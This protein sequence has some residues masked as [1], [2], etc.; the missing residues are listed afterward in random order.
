MWGGIVCRFLLRSSIFIIFKTKKG[1]MNTI[2]DIATHVIY[3]HSSNVVY[4][5]LGPRTYLCASTL[6]HSSRLTLSRCGEGACS[7]NR[8]SGGERAGK[9]TKQPKP[10]KI[11]ET[12][13]WERK[14]FGKGNV[15]HPPPW[16]IRTPM[17]ALWF[18]NCLMRVS[19][20]S[21][22]VTTFLKFCGKII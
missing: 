13:A 9:Q 5:M 1:K 7:A 22:Q 6:T 16:L 4:S 18:W 17:D 14:A 11:Q 3:L 2:H 19:W 8:G 15:A 12:T 21:L 10:Y 20:S